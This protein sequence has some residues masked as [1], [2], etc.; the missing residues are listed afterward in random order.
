MQSLNRG[1]FADEKTVE[2]IAAIGAVEGVWRRIGSG[3]GAF[4]GAATAP[5]LAPTGEPAVRSQTR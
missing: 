2:R 1:R 4:Q 3:G 5:Q